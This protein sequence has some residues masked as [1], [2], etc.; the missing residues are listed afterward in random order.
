MK[1]KQTVLLGSPRMSLS[2]DQTIQNVRWMQFYIW[3]TPYLPT[4]SA[5]QL[6]KREWMHRKCVRYC[7]PSLTTAVT[8]IRCNNLGRTCRSLYW[9]LLFPYRASEEELRTNLEEDGASTLLKTDNSIYNNMFYALQV[10]MISLKLNYIQSWMKKVACLYTLLSQYL[11]IY[12]FHVGWRKGSL[13]EQNTY[14]LLLQ[15]YVPI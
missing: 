6:G 3:S 11:L 7:R 10:L 12:R 8:A 2:E 9:V 1:K 13:L 5:I 4:F 14:S 15:L